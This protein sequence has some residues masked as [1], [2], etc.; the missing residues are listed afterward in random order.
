MEP[1]IR[2]IEEAKHIAIISHVHPDGDAVASL[3]GMR[4][5]LLQLGREVTAVLKDGVPQAFT[6]LEG[7]TDVVDTLPKLKSVDLCLVVDANDAS[8]TGYPEEILAFSEAG[9]LAFIDHHPKG[10][11]VR[12]SKSWLH[13][14]DSASAAELVYQLCHRLGVKVTP[15]LATTLLTGMYTDTGGFQ[16]TNTTT[17][18]LETAA[19]LMRR[20]GKLNKIVHQLQHTKSLAS[21]KLLGIALENTHY[22][23]GGRCVV[24]VITHED[25]QAVH[26]SA[27]DLAGIVN[28]INVLPNTLFCLL[29]CQITPT[30]IRVTARSADDSPVNVSTLAKLMGGG[31][32]PKASGVLFNGKLVKRG[33]SWTVQPA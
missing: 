11:L 30:S 29:I 14:T 15:S 25:M 24:S 5:G 7:A 22:T 2:T 27:E 8:R 6:F 13:D 19:E 32:H 9:K 31:G 17:Q 16:F 1:L 12:L 4:A 10:D 26:A 3:L 28:E 33:S 23:L 18:T 20:G 21:L